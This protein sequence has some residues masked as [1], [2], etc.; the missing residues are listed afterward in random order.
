M[1]LGQNLLHGISVPIE[2]RIV[3]DTLT[4]ETSTGTAKCSLSI[5]TERLPRE[6]MANPAGKIRSL[7]AALCIENLISSATSSTPLT[8]ENISKSMVIRDLPLPYQLHRVNFPYEVPYVTNDGEE[9]IRSI[10]LSNSTENCQEIRNSLLH[11]YYQE[12]QE[13]EKEQQLKNLQRSRTS[14]E[15]IF[16]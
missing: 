1:Y 10:V 13:P 14:K 4:M 7:P 9:R 8:G 11:R 12:V 3:P 6:T 16:T 5:S 15:E 2:L